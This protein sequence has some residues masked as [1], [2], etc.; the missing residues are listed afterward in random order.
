MAILHAPPPATTGGLPPWPASTPPRRQHN[1]AA[2]AA[3]L[4]AAAAGG[5]IAGAIMTAATPT[6]IAAP[7]PEGAPPPAVVSAETRHT[8]D[9]NLCTTYA[10]S[11]A[12]IPKP[13][14]TGMDILP[15]AAMLRAA[16]LE[17]PDASPH[18]RSALNDM[19]TVYDADMAQAARVRPGGLVEPPSRA[20]LPIREIADRAWSM[21]GLDQ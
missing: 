1:R 14:R 7:T 15:A 11:N 5:A 13:D 16:L 2:I 21:C 8:Q 12:V 17:N 6:T 4:I 18:I 9:V 3:A 20:D 10:I 19:V